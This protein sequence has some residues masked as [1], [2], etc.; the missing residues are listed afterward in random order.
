MANAHFKRNVCIGSSAVVSDTVVNP[1]IN[2][3][4]CYSRFPPRMAFI[5]YFYLSFEYF[6]LFVNFPLVHTVVTVLICHSSFQTF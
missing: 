3:N 2:A 4:T 1:I 5:A 6:S